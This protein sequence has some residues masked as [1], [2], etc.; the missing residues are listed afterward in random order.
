MGIVWNI[1]R[2]GIVS[3][4]VVVV[5]E[6]SRRFPR[7]GAVLLSLPMLSVLAFLLSW[8]QHRDMLTISRMARETLILVPLGLPFFV[9]FAFATRLGIGF[10]QCFILGLC[11]STC[12]IVG[13]LFLTPGE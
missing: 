2:V 12:T 4:T 13:W 9:P 7:Y 10:W 11:L 8:I 3:I 1:V 6:I 5:A